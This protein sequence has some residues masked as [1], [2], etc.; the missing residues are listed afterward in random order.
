MMTVAEYLV[1]RD[2][3]R[4]ELEE[5]EKALSDVDGLARNDSFLDS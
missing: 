3:K 5:A 4:K 2:Q 1:E